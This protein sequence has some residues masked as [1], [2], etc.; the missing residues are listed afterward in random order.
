MRKV[1]VFQ[2]VLKKRKFIKLLLYQLVRSVSSEKSTGP[3]SLRCSAP[4]FA[5]EFV[6]APGGIH[7]LLLAGVEGVA[8][9]ADFDV[10]V[11]L[12]GGTGDE[13][14]AAT[15]HD[16]DITVLWVDSLFHGA[17]PHPAL[18]PDSISIKQGKIAFSVLNCN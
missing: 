1:V 2:L 9:G 5:A 4:V 3:S 14:A 16:L 12:K 17:P 13:L 11:L 6:D 10:D 8:S 18:W 7:D 15:T